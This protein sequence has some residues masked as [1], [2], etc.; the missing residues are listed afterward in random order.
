L[1]RAIDAGAH[2]G[3]IYRGPSTP[4]NELWKRAF[5]NLVVFDRIGGVI[6]GRSVGIAEEE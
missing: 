3:M 4:E 2:R 1:R 6:L 5:W